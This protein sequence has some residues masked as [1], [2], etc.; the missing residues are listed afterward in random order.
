MKSVTSNSEL[1]TSLSDENN[2]EKMKIKSLEEETKNLKNENT[3]FRDNILTRLEII[4]NL[5]GN[6]DRGTA[7]TPIIEKT[8]QKK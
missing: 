8:K 3:T 4:E 1:L 7:N 5:Y 6:N 2:C